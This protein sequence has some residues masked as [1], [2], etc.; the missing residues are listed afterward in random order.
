MKALLPILAA[1]GLALAGCGTAP[2]SIVQGETTARP[3]TQAQ[4]A[5]PSNGAIFQA[6][7]YRPHFEDRRAR[8]V[9]DV[10]NIVITERT[11][12]GKNGASAGGKSGSI[13]FKAPGQ[14]AGTSA[15]R[16]PPPPTTSSPTTPARAP[17]TPS[18]APW[19]PPWSRC[20]RTAT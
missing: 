5:A 15:A 8:L 11:S 14:L 10:I 1:A 16:S 17:A 2:T 12:A 18:P 7:A 13:N 9:G 20:C 3:L 4:M 19:A 6:Q